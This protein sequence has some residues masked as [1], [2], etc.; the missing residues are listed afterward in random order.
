MLAGR[1]RS[2]ATAGGDAS[3]LVTGTAA[4][5][6]ALS[7]SAGTWAMGGAPFAYQWQR[8][9]AGGGNCANLAGATSTTARPR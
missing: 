2:T 8:C 6:Q 9:D 7:S 4:V 3:P 5:N 1:Q